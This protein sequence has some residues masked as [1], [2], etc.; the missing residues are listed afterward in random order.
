MTNAAEQY[1]T[2]AEQA[3]QAGMPAEAQVYALLAIAE[4]LRSLKIRL[5]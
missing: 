2:A 4:E 5:S 1:K 3:I